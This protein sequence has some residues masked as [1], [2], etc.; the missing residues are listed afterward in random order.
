MILYDIYGYPMVIVFIYGIK[1]TYTD[2]PISTKY[3]VL[4][5]VF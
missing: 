1:P 5:I 2:V 4:V 3:K